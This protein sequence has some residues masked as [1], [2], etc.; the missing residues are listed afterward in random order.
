MAAGLASGLWKGFDELKEINQDGRTIFKPQISEQASRRLY[1]RWERA[2]EI[3]RGWLE[4]HT[5]N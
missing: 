5:L 2:V 4:P 3:S 1:G